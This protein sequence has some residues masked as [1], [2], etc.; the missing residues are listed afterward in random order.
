MRV[1]INTLKSWVCLRINLFFLLEKQHPVE[2][3][4]I[5]QSAN[6]HI[7]MSSQI[8]QPTHYLL[9]CSDLQSK[10]DALTRWTGIPSNFEASKLQQERWAT[11]PQSGYAHLPTLKLPNLNPPT[12]SEG[13]WEA[14]GWVRIMKLE[15]WRK[16]KSHESWWRAGAEVN[17]VEVKAVNRQP[18]HRGDKMSVCKMM[19]C[20]RW[21]HKCVNWRIHIKHQQHVF[22]PSRF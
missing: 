2:F 4:R 13:V 12:R 6:R 1:L 19:W 20:E 14:C 7:S 8:C 5:P 18:G 15:L 3:L 9:T 10:N 17:V 11:N 21:T 22:A 16:S